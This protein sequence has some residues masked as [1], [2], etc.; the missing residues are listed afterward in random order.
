MMKLIIAVVRR[1][2]PSHRIPACLVA[3]LW[4]HGVLIIFAE[5]GA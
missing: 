1:K 3:K 5:N 4:Q 2:P